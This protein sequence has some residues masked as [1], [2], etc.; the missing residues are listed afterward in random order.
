MS[1][2]KTN[3]STIFITVALMIVPFPLHF[4]A[5]IPLAFNDSGATYMHPINLLSMCTFVFIMYFIWFFIS[6]KI[7][8]KKKKL[9]KQL[10]WIIT[11][12]VP[13]T[14][15]LW[16]L[17]TYPMVNPEI[18]QIE[19][20]IAEDY[21]LVEEFIGEDLTVQYYLSNEKVIEKATT[22]KNVKYTI[23]P[24]IEKNILLR[25]L[26]YVKRINHGNLSDGNTQYMAS[27]NYLESDNIE[28]VEL[29]DYNENN[30][31]DYT[32]LEFIKIKDEYFLK[33]H[34]YNDELLIVINNIDKNTNYYLEDIYDMYGIYRVDD[35]RYQKSFGLVNIA[36]LDEKK[37]NF[38]IINGNYLEK[39]EMDFEFLY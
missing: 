11:M 16:Y 17:F 1:N 38:K 4:M 13:V 15:I 22:S 30:T 18:T 2:V 35:M 12:I 36:R 9:N 31:L 26:D 32:S 7:L 10:Y 8:A 34:I 23:C 33:R 27:T 37:S 14:F 25:L 29:Y 3:I 20:D 28:I 5:I 19:K 21:S 6:Y 24:K 39:P